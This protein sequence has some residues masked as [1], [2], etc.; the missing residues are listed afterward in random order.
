[1]KEEKQNKSKKI[2]YRKK[3]KPTVGEKPKQKVTYITYDSD[4]GTFTKHVNGVEAPFD[5]KTEIAL[6]PSIDPKSE[7]RNEF[8]EIEKSDFPIKDLLK[9]L[10]GILRNK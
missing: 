8:I 2:K 3:K 6:P 4:Y 1:M 7:T 5:P 10:L 9:N